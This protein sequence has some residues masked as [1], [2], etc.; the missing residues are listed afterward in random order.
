MT[1]IP[2]TGRLVTRPAARPRVEYRL[3]APS[4]SW[5]R[6]VF[7]SLVVGV[8][9]VPALGDE[10]LWLPVGVGVSLLVAAHT[11]VASRNVP[12]IPGLIALIALLQWVLVPWAAYHVPPTFPLYAMVIPADQYFSFAVPAS[13]AL[14]AGLY[15]PLYRERTAVPRMPSRGTPGLRL[16]RQTSEI[17]VWGGLVTQYVLVDV[18]PRSLGFATSLIGSL[19]YVGAF[20][21]ALMRARGWQWRVLAVLGA[22]VVRASTE[23]MFHDLLLWTAY[24]GL[25]LAFIHRTPVRRLVV[26]AVAGFALILALNGIKQQYRL[27]LETRTE[28]TA[29]QR[30]E[31]LGSVLGDM[32]S[33]PHALLSAENV[34]LNVTRLN[35]GWIIAR[36]LSHVPAA[37]PFAEGETVR[38]SLEAT[39]L[40]RVLAPNKLVIGGHEYFERFTGV[41]LASGTSMDLSI[42]G[43]LY[44]N[45]GRTGGILG[46]LVAGLLLGLLF[47][48][49]V[50]WSRES[51]LWWA[52]APYVMLYTAKAEGGLAEP[53]N[54]VV[55]S[56]VVMVAVIMVL[57]GWVMLRRFHFRLRARRAG[58]SPDQLR[59]PD[60]PR[61]ERLGEGLS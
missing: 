41:A 51:V 22:L 18:V 23:G 34:S 33:N 47:R 14:V 48:V 16:L 37:E 50:R 31:T 61:P 49:F 38:A 27:L 17:M 19:S 10:S 28:L 42:A 32:I 26:F 40:P 46:L 57:P 21:L 30:V 3:F 53:M 36:I 20:T 44:A 56:F 11:L 35:Q 59:P 54:H 60:L 29:L 1:S 25:T 2:A 45:F 24:L 9:L 13:M 58:T 15:A 43:E 39:L 55:K 8:M 7:V 6:I 4:G 12:W 5:Q 52:W